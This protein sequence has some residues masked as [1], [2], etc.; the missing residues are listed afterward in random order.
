MEF[1]NEKT[2]CQKKKCFLF[3]FVILETQLLFPR[4]KLRKSIISLLLRN[5]HGA[6]ILCK[7]ARHDF[8]RYK[9]RGESNFPRMGFKWKNV[10]TLAL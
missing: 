10:R 7:T 8:I 2:G 9:A 1:N 4:G 3:V 5:Y 6:V